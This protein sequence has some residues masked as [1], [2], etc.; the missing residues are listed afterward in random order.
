MLFQLVY[1]IVAAATAIALGLWALLHVRDVSFV[2]L[3]LPT[4]ASAALLSVGY[5]FALGLHWTRTRRDRN[6]GVSVGMT[7]PRRFPSI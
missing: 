3:F 2:L 6:Y 1:L 7:R 5:L 4:L